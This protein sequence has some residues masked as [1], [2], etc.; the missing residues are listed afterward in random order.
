MIDVFA[1]TAIS[2]GATTVGTSVGTLG[3]NFVV[4]AFDD[5]RKRLL[6]RLG[7]YYRCPQ[8]VRDHIHIVGTVQG[9]ASD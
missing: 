9:V 2:G 4:A 7:L 8:V 5:D 6:R 1:T 3:R